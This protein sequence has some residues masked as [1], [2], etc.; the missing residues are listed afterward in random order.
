M[1]E[2]HL[3]SASGGVSADRRAQ[4]SWGISRGGTLLASHQRDQ[5]GFVLA[6]GWEA[7]LLPFT[8]RALSSWTKEKD[9]GLRAPWRFQFQRVDCLGDF[10]E[11]CHWD[12]EG[13]CLP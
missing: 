13:S 2:K 5:A 4:P 9:R 3:L 10:S 11:L 6:A 12:P 1:P 8:G 7:P